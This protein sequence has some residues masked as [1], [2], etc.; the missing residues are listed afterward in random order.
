MGRW[1]Y[2]REMKSFAFF[3]NIGQPS[4]SWPRLSILLSMALAFS[5]CDGSKKSGASIGKELA[6]LSEPAEARSD[7]EL[8]TPIA[9]QRFCGDC[10]ELPN[11][12]SFVREV[13][14][15]E[16]HKGF[17]FYARSGRTDLHPPPLEEVLK[18]YRQRSP[19]QFAFPEPPSLDSDWLARFDRESFD[20]K[21]GNY[22][23]PAVSSIRWVEFQ[24]EGDRRLVVTDM[25]E[26][27]VNSVTPVPK[28]TTRTLIDR[29]GVPA[30]VTPCDLNDD[31]RTDL[32]V[33]DLGSFNPYDHALG[34]AVWLKRDAATRDF[35]SITIAEKLG[36]VADVAVADFSS[37]GKLDLLIAEFGHRQTGSI[38][39]FTN[40][41]HDQRTVHFAQN[42]IDIRPGAMQVLAND[43]NGDGAMDFATVLSQEFECVELFVNQGRKFD[44]HRAATGGDLTFGSVGIELVDLDQDGDQDILYVNGDTFDNNFANRSH[45]LQWLENV[46]NLEFRL[47]RLL[48]L[49]GAY[50]AVAT[51]IDG[52][53]DLDILVVA[54]L[55][56][57]VYPTS[58]ND[59]SPASIVLLEQ[60]TDLQFQV[61][62]LERGTPRYPALEAADFNAD[63]K[64]DF[65]V[66]VQL[67]ETDPPNSA[68]SKLPRLTFWWQK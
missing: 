53:S 21:D 13:W 36:R 59:R 19:V 57:I 64:M 1:S 10:H 4:M 5:G 26:G 33:A 9:I 25:R 43:W 22:V 16:I 27:S 15:D 51:D 34:R 55:P 60:T 29:V 8:P 50:R 65:A 35:E 67:F 2:F 3:Q 30:R 23:T 11:P 63:G 54:N 31:G 32:V 49:P 28:K 18:Y 14:Y 39:L 62:V 68:S 56:T 45:G 6:H 42:V 66:G 37:D 47:H 24:P 20:W 17:E 7:A 46:G 41:I 38:R 44:R 61:H 48:D 58:L 52:D 40:Q 12:T